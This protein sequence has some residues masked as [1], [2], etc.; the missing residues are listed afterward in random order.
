[1][2]FLACRKI[3]ILTLHFII[4]WYMFLVPCDRGSKKQDSLSRLLSCFHIDMRSYCHAIHAIMMP[5][6]CQFVMFWK[7]FVHAVLSCHDGHI[8]SL[9]ILPCQQS[10]MLACFGKLHVAMHC[11]A[12]MFSWH[13]VIADGETGDYELSSFCVN[14]KSLSGFFASW[15]RETNMPHYVSLGWFKSFNWIFKLLNRNLI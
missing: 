11:H 4:F 1:M 2:E 6:I 13:A 12:V 3:T 14:S 5:C 15:G 10:V 7:C 9:V 8:V